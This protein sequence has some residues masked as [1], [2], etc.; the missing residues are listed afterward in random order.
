M[1]D[2][3]STFAGPCPARAGQGLFCYANGRNDL[4]Q[5]LLLGYGKKKFDLFRRDLSGHEMGV[6]CDFSA[7]LRGEST[8]LQE[9]AVNLLLIVNTASRCGFTP[10]YKGLEELYRTHG[11]QG[12]VLFGFPCNQFE[13]REPGGDN[14]I[15]EFCSTSYGVTFP[16]FRKIE[17]N[18]PKSA[19]YIVSSSMKRKDFSDQAG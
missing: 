7:S 9:I 5:Y 14:E 13:A 4:I 1:C 19:L 11:P 2:R 10:Q 17:V 3:I 18:G 8:P 16:I 12:F 15:A 6:V